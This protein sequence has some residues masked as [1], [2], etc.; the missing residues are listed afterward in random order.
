MVQHQGSSSGL[1]EENDSMKQLLEMIV[2][3]IERRVADV[4]QEKPTR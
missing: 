4:A 2:A 3:E 1:K